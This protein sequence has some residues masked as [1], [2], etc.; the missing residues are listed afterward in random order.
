MT[1]LHIIKLPVRLRTHFV[2]DQ[3]DIWRE[4]KF[5]IT[6]ITHF[7]CRLCHLQISSPCL[8]QT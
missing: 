3:A 4:H 7:L 1:S 6:F 8:T 2:I 5:D